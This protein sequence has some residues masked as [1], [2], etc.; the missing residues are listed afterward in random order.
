MERDMKWSI[1][2]VVS[3]LFAGNIFF[4]KRLVD[5]VDETKLMV[6]ALHEQ[7]SVI[8]SQLKNMARDAACHVFPKTQTREALFNEGDRKWQ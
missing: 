1:S 2:F 8:D 5:E 7:V 4:V 6:V 3:I